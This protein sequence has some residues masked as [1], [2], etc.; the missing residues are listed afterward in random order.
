MDLI[1]DNLP[2]SEDEGHIFLAYIIVA[3]ARMIYIME[4]HTRVQK[5]KRR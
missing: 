5:S 4:S 1:S 2:M 3:I